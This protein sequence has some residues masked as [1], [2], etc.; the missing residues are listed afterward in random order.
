MVDV[1]DTKKLYFTFSRFVHLNLTVTYTV[2]SFLLVTWSC[3]DGVTDTVAAAE[4]MRSQ[5]Q[6]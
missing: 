2:S 4:N 5:H 1:V 6:Q 3:C